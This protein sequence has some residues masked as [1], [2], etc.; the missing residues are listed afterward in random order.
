[1]SIPSS[2]RIL[3]RRIEALES[4]ARRAAPQKRNLLLEMSITA[5]ALAWTPDEVEEILAAAERAS[6]D[7]LPPDLGRRWARSLDC[8]SRRCFGKSFGALL[9]SQSTNAEPSASRA[10]SSDDADPA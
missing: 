1:M 4:T 8:I 3:I 6:I 7:E 9:V 10:A 5:M 2:T